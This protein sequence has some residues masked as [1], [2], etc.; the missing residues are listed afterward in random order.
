MTR[1]DGNTQLG[2]P[3]VSSHEKI[4][5]KTRPVQSDTDVGAALSDKVFY[6]LVGVTAVVG[7]IVLVVVLSAHDVGTQRAAGLPS[8]SCSLSVCLTLAR[9]P[10]SYLVV[11]NTLGIA[12][13]TRHDSTLSDAVKWGM[14]DAV[15]GSV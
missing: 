12:S 6:V 10:T 15:T 8:L 1:A 5:K 2:P 4:D 9:C 13:G 11:L 14:S 7:T 3:V